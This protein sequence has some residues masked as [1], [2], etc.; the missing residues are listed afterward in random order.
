MIRSDEILE[1][2]SNG[3][4][5]QQQEVPSCSRSHHQ[6]EEKNNSKTLNC[7]NSTL[8]NSRD[9]GVVMGGLSSPSGDRLIVQGYNNQVV[10]SSVTSQSSEQPLLSASSSEEEVFCED[11]VIIAV[12]DSSDD[13]KGSERKDV[14][15]EKAAR[16]KQM[17]ANV[18][19]ILLFLFQLA[20]N[21][22]IVVVY[23]VLLCILLYLHKDHILHPE[24]HSGKN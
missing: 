1:N 22:L 19:Q 12:G 16:G 13:L 6:L 23:L 11:S 7:D 3:V 4:G 9:D 24:N 18:K 10:G 15:P 14:H 5:A 20:H 21:K 8:T 2:L 17:W